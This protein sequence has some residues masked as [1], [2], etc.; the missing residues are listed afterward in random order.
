MI[1]TGQIIEGRGGLYTVVNDAG[2]SFILRAKNRFRREGITPLVGDKVRFTPGQLEEHGW[3]EEIL[4]RTS[5]SIRPPV[6][7]ISQLIITM[8][9]EPMP[10]MLLLDKL[11]V[12]AREQHILP[13]LVVNKADLDENLPV[14]LKAAYTAADVKVL[15]VSA[16]TGQG[17][18]QL[19]TLMAGHLNCFAGQ[20]GVGKS[21]LISKFTGL[22]LETGE[23]SHRIRRGRQTTR[24]TTLIHHDGL[25]VLDTPGFSL[26]ELPQE[27]EPEHLREHYPEYVNLQSQCRFEVCLHD[28][29][30]A[31]AVLDAVRAGELDAER[32][33]RYQQLLSLQKEKWS[34]RYA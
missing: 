19:K 15:A 20:S 3:L 17:I 23:V 11:L 24:H 25:Q 8:A 34:N 10:D 29:E 1:Q 4:P 12:F 13:L 31:C 26:F 7:N 22:D 9:P 5:L 27:M 18:E 30:P 28:Q 16:M 32:H 2:E 33:A 14:R 6:A 21:T